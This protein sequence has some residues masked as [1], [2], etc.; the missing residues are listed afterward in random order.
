M[1]GW[2][3]KIIR[4]NLNSGSISDEELDVQM[5][6]EYIGA[7]GFGISILLDELNPECDPLGPENVLVHG[8]R[9]P[10]GD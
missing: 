5:A 8:S 4:V 7:R 1:H 9:T 10:Y 3:G 2:A 6:R